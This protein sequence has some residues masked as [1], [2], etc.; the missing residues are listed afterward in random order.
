MR[1]AEKNKIKKKQ[2]KR[3]DTY[4]VWLNMLKSDM[5]CARWYHSFDNFLRE[6]GYLPSKYHY[7]HLKGGSRLYCKE[8]CLWL[9]SLTDHDILEL[10]EIFCDPNYIPDGY[11]Y[12]L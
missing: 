10:S 2:N 9:R 5:V 1:V 4:N 6:M 11:H 3:A 7:L 8:N 12:R